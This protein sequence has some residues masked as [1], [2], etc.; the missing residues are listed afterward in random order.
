M[1]TLRNANCKGIGMFGISFEP[2]SGSLRCGP[3]QRHLS[4][5][6][7][8]VLMI[9]ERAGAGRLV[10]RQELME[11]VWSE[12]NVGDEALTVVISRLR[13]HFDCLGVDG[14]IIQTVPKA[15]YRLLPP[16]S[17]LFESRQTDLPAARAQRLAWAALV[18]AAFALLLA[19]VRFAL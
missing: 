18:V 19:L 13:H 16:D 10:R 4:P 15:G 6:E 1:E 8:R 17:W 11:A 3:R 7:A 2:D 12:Q 14:K 5:K 9:L